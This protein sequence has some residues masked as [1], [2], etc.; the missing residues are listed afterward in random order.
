MVTSEQLA[1][2]WVESS[3][4]D[5]GAMITLFNG[6]KYSWSL[7][8]GQLVL[9]KLLKAIFAKRNADAPHAPRIHNLLLLSKKCNLE[10]TKD[11]EGNLEVITGFNLSARYED[12]K[13]EFYNRC[14]REYAS[15]QI[16]IIKELRAW[17]KKELIKA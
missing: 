14:T 3:D 1:K 16:A 15:E 10:L 5:F 13:K 12:F 4:E 7:F 6:K 11:R 17:L 9:E 2:H 8:V